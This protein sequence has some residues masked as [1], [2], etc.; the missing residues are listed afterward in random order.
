MNNKEII[1]E[2]KNCITL[3]HTTFSGLGRSTSITRDHIVS[4]LSYIQAT[5]IHCGL[6][7]MHDNGEIEYNAET[8]V[9][10]LLY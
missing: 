9:I 5:N 6:L 7:E 2:I 10:L 1:L 4:N 3:A 8:G